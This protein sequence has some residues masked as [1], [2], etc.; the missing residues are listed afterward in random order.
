MK[1]RFLAI[2][3]CLFV[4]VPSPYPTVFADDVAEV[5]IPCQYII[6]NVL[7]NTTING[8]IAGN[9]L[10]VSMDTIEELTGAIY[11]REEKI[12]GFY[13]PDGKTANMIYWFDEDTGELREESIFYP[14]RTWIIPHM[15]SAD[16][17]LLVSLDYMLMALNT[18]MAVDP[19]ASIPLVVYHPYTVWDARVRLNRHPEYLFSWSEIDPSSDG[20][21]VFM[22]S[23]LNSLLL[24]YDSHFVSD[25][26]FSWAD[27]DILNASEQQCMDAMV[28]IMSCFS[29]VTFDMTD[30]I[31][32]LVAEQNA[33]AISVADKLMTL[34]GVEADTIT[35]F[36]ALSDVSE[37]VFTIVEQVNE[38]LV[39]MQISKAQK[40]LLTDTF[41]KDREGSFLNQKDLKAVR[42]AAQHLY[43]R[44]D[45][46]ALGTT[47]AAM[48][49]LVDVF[50][51]A[52]MDK[53]PLIAVNITSA[54]V[55]LLPG[56]SDTNNRLMLATHCMVL[57][58]L[59]LGELAWI[60]NKQR[61][62]KTSEELLYANRQ[63]M[64]FCLQASYTARQLLIETGLC[65][66]QTVTQMEK[67]NQDV[68]DFILFLQGCHTIFAPNELQLMYEK[69]SDYA[70]EVAPIQNFVSLY[71][72]ALT[73]RKGVSFHIRKFGEFNDNTTFAQE[74]TVQKFGT[75]LATVTGNSHSTYSGINI[76]NNTPYS[77][78]LDSPFTFIAADMH[79]FDLVLPTPEAIVSVSEEKQSDG[80]K[81]FHVVYD[82]AAIEKETCGLVNGV[83][84]NVGSSPDYVVDWEGIYYNVNSIAIPDEGVHPVKEFSMDVHFSHNNELQ[85]IGITYYLVGVLQDVGYFRGTTFFDVTASVEE[86]SDHTESIFELLPTEFVFSSGAGGWATQITLNTDG[87]FTGK[88]YDSEMGDAKA[89]YPNGTVY[90]CNFQGIFS[91]PQKVDDYIYSMHLEKFEVEKPAGQVYYEDHFRYITSDPYGFGAANEFLIY[92]PGCPLEETSEEFLSW[93]FI[94][95]QIR[96]TIPTG[97][98]GI[99]NVG[100]MKGFMGEDDNSIWRR[101]YTYSYNSY[102]SELQ[103]SYYSES[104]LNFWPES[105]AATLVL[106]FDWSDDDQTEFIASDYRGTGE[107]NISLDFNEDFSSVTVNVKSISGFNLEPWGGTVDG[108]IS[109]EYQVKE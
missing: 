19:N 66:P 75:D 105:G 9:Y 15:Y 99:Y 64:L 26:F 14:G 77:Y 83:L 49:M 94:N 79:G 60:Q 91:Q 92:L 25:V 86:I 84:P 80:G 89:E 78:D 34:L 56:V 41:L 106:G 40:N 36:K 35:S 45:V 29:N 73:R 61:S 1:K 33:D 18:K 2:L 50:S 5:N 24:D 90:I 67:T 22:I 95:T 57:N 109:V 59:A 70:D 55:N 97:V 104:H 10:Y 32:Y 58:D 53:T 69:W 28:E 71:E 107:Y 65:S 47:Y 87:A 54:I 16:G 76:P 30:S 8:Q 12:L 27:E 44:L 101:T 85:T 93:S 102:R 68:M 11:I 42:N 108:T 63:V 39:Y 88:Y 31:D 6:G 4:F 52:V 20:K 96:N 51:N 7:S 48:D 38:L 62:E 98:Y 21:S 81:V 74:A 43:N 37:N 23:S 103:P 3:L 46:S 72:Q 13:D 17:E 82:S 100:G